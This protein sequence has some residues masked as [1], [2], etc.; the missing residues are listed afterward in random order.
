MGRP[1]YILVNCEKPRDAAMCNMGTGFVVLSHHRLFSIH[2]LFNYCW[3]LFS[4]S[5]A[6]LCLCLQTQIFSLITLSARVIRNGNNLSKLK[7]HK[8]NGTTRIS[9]DG[10]AVKILY[11]RL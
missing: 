2:Q 5:I 7:I 1:G 6:A 4:T 8:Q 3:S 10:D 9:T 11:Q